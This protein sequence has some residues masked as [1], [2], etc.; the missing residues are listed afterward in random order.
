[1]R[2]IKILVE[3]D[4]TDFHGWQVQENLRTVQGELFR[5]VRQ[6]TSESVVVEGAGRTDR[7]VHARGQV[8]NF[9]IEK[10]VPLLD[11]RKGLNA[12][13]PADIRVRSIDEVDEEFHAR[14]SAVERRYRY[15]ISAVPVA[16]GRQYCWYYSYS[17]DLAAMN[18]ACRWL[19]GERSFKSFCLSEAEVSHYLCD[20]RKAVWTE[21]GPMRTFEIHANRFLHN[22]VRCLVG[23]MALVGRGKID[24]EE[25][26][27]I[28]E[29]EDR[30]LAGF[31]APASGLVLEEVVY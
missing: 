31:T 29:R 22:M 20:V 11:L 23:T 3:Y 26:K 30:R 15:Y 6:I 10:S 12:V 14:F 4:G 1:M 2:N 21:N 18:A 24:A 8:A 7:G 19:V 28:M 5:A 13:L 16:I 25:V 17:L 9:K 27:R